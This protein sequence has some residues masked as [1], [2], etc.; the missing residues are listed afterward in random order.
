M[1]LPLPTDLKT[2]T[3]APDK[4]ARL[5]NCYVEERTN[6]VRK[7]CCA[8]GGIQ[9]GTGIAQGG[10]AFNVGTTPY[11]FT[12]NGDVPTIGGTDGGV[13]ASY[14]LGAQ[15]QY[16]LPA[17]KYYGQPPNYLIDFC[18][19]AVSYTLITD[20]LDPYKNKY[21]MVPAAPLPLIAGDYF[22]P[23]GGGAQQIVAVVPAGYIVNASYVSPITWGFLVPTLPSGEPN[24][25]VISPI[26][27]QSLPSLIEKIREYAPTAP[28]NKL[29]IKVTVTTA[30]FGSRV[31]FTGLKTQSI[32]TIMT[33]LSTTF[34]FDP[35]NIS[36]RIRDERQFPV[37]ITE[38]TT[39]LIP[40]GSV[41]GTF[42]LN[43][44]VDYFF[45]ATSP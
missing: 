34:F 29:D 26:I 41:V 44:D 11:V 23:G 35:S 14:F 45:L 22:F 38:T 33:G 2:R 19:I 5:K 8:A 24:F 37:T 10:I 1:R 25:T 30:G 3:G 39:S 40:V 6:A 13:L 12:V 43:N 20:P 18:S 27:S 9:A 15:T 31:V 32:S 28:S 16:T 7:R 21:L 42:N 17:G 36:I 4:D